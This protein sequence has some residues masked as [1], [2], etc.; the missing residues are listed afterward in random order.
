MMSL[1]KLRVGV[2]SYYLAQIASGL[3]E[4]YTGAGE[5]PGRWT[6][7][8][9]PLLDLDG[10][11]AG[12][13][14]RAVLAGLA[15]NTGLTPNGIQLTTHPRRVP[16]FDLTFAVPKSVST[17]YALGDPLVQQAFVA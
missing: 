10:Q 4:Y 9:A 3:D 8:G 1:W 6:G 15:P 14:L 17:V 2:E 13:D 7:S 5:A 11:V 12:D 16:G